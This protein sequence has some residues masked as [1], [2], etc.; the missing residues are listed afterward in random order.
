MM[1]KQ[2]IIF[3]LVS[4]ACYS[5]GGYLLWDLG[6][7]GALAFVSIIAGVILSTVGNDL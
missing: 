7:T 4:I 1:S 5:F 3:G 2:K 6:W